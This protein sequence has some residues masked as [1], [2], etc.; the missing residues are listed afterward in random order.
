LEI[1]KAE[2]QS[3]MA[4]DNIS[5]IDYINRIEPMKNEMSRKFSTYVDYIYGERKYSGIDIVN[6]EGDNKIRYNINVE[7]QD[8][9]SSG[10]S[11]VKMFCMDMLIWD[12]QKNSNVQFLYHD[13]SLFAE[14]DPRQC[15]RMLKIAN[16]MCVNQKKQ[17]IL[18]MN[19]DMFDNIIEAANDAEDYLFVQHLIE[20][21]RLN[22]YDTSPQ[23]K[24]LGVQ[25]K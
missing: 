20:S 23:D 14:T 13:G 24:L 5:S 16:D 18:N 17:Y 25:I 15:Y 19:Y 7:I 8:D 2:F 6:N 4:K 21:V 11:N 1:K 12:I 3:E 9:G 22:L 10:I